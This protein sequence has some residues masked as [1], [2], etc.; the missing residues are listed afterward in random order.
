MLTIVPS[1]WDSP[2]GPRECNE[3]GKI[4]TM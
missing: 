3:G 1:V 4:N 2:E